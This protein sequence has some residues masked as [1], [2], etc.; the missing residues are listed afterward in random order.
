MSAHV[1]R[2]IEA[3]LGDRLQHVI[4]E[5]AERGYHFIEYLKGL[6]EGRSTFWP[7]PTRPVTLL[8][9]LEGDDVVGMALPL[10]EVRQ[11]ALRGVV[12]HMLSG[13]VVVNDL[14]AAKRLFAQHPAYTVVTLDGE[15]VRPGGVVTGGVMEGPAV[16]AMQKK[17]EIGELQ[18]E[19]TTLE[20]R[21][22]ELI[23]RHYKLQKHM[24]QTEGVLKGLEKNRHQEELS[25]ASHEKDLHQAGS[26]LV[27]LRE[28]I[29]GVDAERAQLAASADAM[30]H[31]LE[32][33]RGEVMHGQTD[34]EARDERVRLL[35]SEMESLKA[36]MEALSTES[37]SLK[38]K[39]A[40]G[41]ERGSAAR[42][43]ADQ[44]V[45]Q[46][47]ELTERVGR[48]AAAKDEGVARIADLERASPKRRPTATADSSSGW[49][50]GSLDAAR[51][52]HVEAST[53]GDARC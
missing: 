15:V 10:I 41:S 22:N 20:E 43:K 33:S 11:A 26:G 18:G 48:L 44:L 51:R 47:T 24:G 8:A 9:P 12:E 7:V 1:E 28:R 17:R 38:V 31:D 35:E 46:L 37:T 32:S 13:V 40:S 42:Q 16:G 30:A 5:N 27:K 36:T 45:E 21:Y 23:T 52:A 25:L 49:Q 39:V 2:A 4:V 19:L 34:R 50:A 29:A 14:E 53:T 3:A 6:A